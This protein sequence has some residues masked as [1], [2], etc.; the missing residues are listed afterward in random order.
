MDTD[1]FSIDSK[2]RKKSRLKKYSDKSSKDKD[3]PRSFFSDHKPFDENDSYNKPFLHRSYIG[4]FVGATNYTL[5]VESASRK[6]LEWVLGF[7]ISGAQLIIPNFLMD[8]TLSTH[9]GAPQFF[10]DFSTEASGFFIL[11]EIN[12]PF[13]L[14]KLNTGTL[15]ASVGPVINAS[16]FDFTIENKKE[17]YSNIKIGGVLSLGLGYSLKEYAL[18]IEPKLYIDKE[19]YWGGI[20]ALQKSF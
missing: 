18:K 10:D 7:K 9:W 16:F 17:N 20:V 2:N 3:S 14:K 13:L 19:V 15:Y 4:G 1:I 11:A 8:I 6:S 12:M 5:E